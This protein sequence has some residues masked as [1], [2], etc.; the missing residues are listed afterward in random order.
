MIQR[1]LRFCGILSVFLLVATGFSGCSKRMKGYSATL[2]K[3]SDVEQGSGV[4]P[5]V[6]Y[7]DEEFFDLIAKIE[8]GEFEPE[9]VR[10]QE[11][12]DVP[13]PIIEVPEG[14]TIEIKEKLFLTQINDIY[15]NFENYKEKTIIVEGMFT[16]LESYDGDLKFPAVYRRGPGCCGNDGWGGFM[17]DF[18]GKYPKEDDWIRVVGKPFIREENGYED[19]YLKVSSLEIKTERGAEFVQN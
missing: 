15:F 13:Q 10:Q 18:K 6:V 9:P 2:R 7:D 4:N 5:A 19:L 11:I 8:S 16:F 12:P 1:L 3:S 17:L 14:K